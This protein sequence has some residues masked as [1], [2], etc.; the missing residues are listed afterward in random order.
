MD[1]HPVPHHSLLPS[2]SL[3]VIGHLHLMSK[4]PQEQ[5]RC[6]R[7]QYGDIFS[8]Q[9]GCSTL[10]VISSYRLLKEAFIKLG[11]YFS[12]RPDLFVFNFMGNKRGV[13]LSSGETW[14]EHRKVVL[15]ILREMGLGKNILAEKIQQ[16]VVDFLKELEDKNGLSFNPCS[17]LH[18]SIANIISSVVWGQHYRHSDPH[19]QKY[20]TA[21]VDNMRDLGGDT[22]VLN[23]LP[24]LRF[25]PGD[26]FGFNRVGKRAQMIRLF[27]IGIYEEHVRDFDESYAK[28][29]VSAYIREMR[30][31]A[32]SGEPTTL[33]V[34]NLLQVV[35][36][37]FG[38]GMETTATTISWAIAYF[39]HNPQVQDKCY[40]E[41][42]EKIGAG[43]LPTLQDKTSLPYLE[44]T[45]ME[46][47]RKGN[48][49]PFAIQHSVS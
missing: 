12:Y 11:D 34:E 21:L 35:G 14:K 40:Q 32:A 16:E 15:D 47:M 22:A 9:L 17:T 38:A 26:L 8:C 25:L 42:Q 30:K 49:A 5:F 46:V 31:K 6:W 29:F 13:A 19:F 44:A 4:D 39:L 28:D 23:F 24:W 1:N 27:L 7:Q 3:P 20:I 10:V 18:H 43:R 48:I 41:L 2:Y 36:D 45:I 33:S 37:L